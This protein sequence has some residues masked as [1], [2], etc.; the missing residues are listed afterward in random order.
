MGARLYKPDRGAVARIAAAYGHRDCELIED[1]LRAAGGSRADELADEFK[2]ANEERHRLLR[3]S[4][5]PTPPL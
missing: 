5:P 2:A 1:S 3:I 4:R